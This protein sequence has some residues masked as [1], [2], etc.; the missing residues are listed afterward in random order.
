MKKVREWWNG[1][2]LIKKSNIVDYKVTDF[3][4]DSLNRIDKD[5]IR[6]HYAKTFIDESLPK[7]TPTWEEE[8][9]PPPIVPDLSKDLDDLKRE[10]KADEL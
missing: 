7:Q 5:L 8:H 2:P 9:N 10:S 6:M 3:E 4:W 1:L